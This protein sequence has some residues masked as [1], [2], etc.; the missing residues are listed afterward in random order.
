MLLILYAITLYLPFCKPMLTMVT[1]P[2][3]SPPPPY[4][5]PPGQS[6]ARNLHRPTSSRSPSALQTSLPAPSSLHV[7]EYASPASA[8]TVISP[9]SG[10]NRN[11]PPAPL[12]FPPPPSTS[13]RDRSTSRTR[14]EGRS[15]FNLSA[16]TSRGKSSDRSNTT[17]AID[18]LQQS[19]S[20]ALARAPGQWGS[21]SPQPQ[22]YVHVCTKLEMV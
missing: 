10:R 13:S 15:R 8:V 21:P 19:T 3:P 12:N 7:A 2:L 20:E 22:L 11:D 17:K 1:A 14:P 18:S 4:S 16:L 6:I 5:P 9:L